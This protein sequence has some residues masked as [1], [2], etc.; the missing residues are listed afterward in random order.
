MTATAALLSVVATSPGSALAQTARPSSDKLLQAEQSILSSLSA[1]AVSFTQPKASVHASAPDVKNA[2]EINNV[3]GQGN[4]VQSNGVQ[5]NS[6]QSDSAPS[7]ALEDAL[8]APAVSMDNRAA[9]AVGA[10]LSSEPRA[11]TSLAAKQVIEKR[12]SDETVTSPAGKPVQEKIPTREAPAK[13]VPPASASQLRTSNAL[14]RSQ[15]EQRELQVAALTKQVQELQSQLT[16]AEV[17]VERLSAVMDAKTRASL[18]Q[19]K[20]SNALPSRVTTTPAEEP[21]RL[22]QGGAQRQ[23]PARD[24]QPPAPDS[25]LEV[26][27]IAVAK[28]DLRLGPGANHSALLSLPRGSRLAVEMRQGEWLRVFA[29]SGERAWIHASLVS[30][31]GSASSS[32]AE[33][34]SAVAVKGFSSSVE[35]EAFRRFQ[36]GKA[37][38]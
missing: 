30:F 36:R 15:L 3:P 22:A 14:L 35:E 1:R 7:R 32:S 27:T 24:V 37:A 18:G 17:E 29:P 19:F 33:T 5:R 28:A 25:N 12:P 10:T 20:V 31:G 2:P 21:A 11:G 13:P 16:M 23:Y 26:A 8:P 6:V 9:I 38:H 34:Q 4:G